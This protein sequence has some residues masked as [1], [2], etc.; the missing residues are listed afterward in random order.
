MTI[1]SIRRVWLLWRWEV[2]AGLA[3]LAFFV[4]TFWAATVWAAVIHA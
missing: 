2:A 1:T 4:A 3:L